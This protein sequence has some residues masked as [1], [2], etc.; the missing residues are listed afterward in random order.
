MNNEI[1]QNGSGPAFRPFEFIVAP[2]AALLGLKAIGARIRGVANSL[3]NPGF[4]AYKKT[5]LEKIRSTWAGKELLADP[6]LLG[7]RDLHIKVGKKNKDFRASPESLRR[8]FLERGRFAKINTLVDVYNLVS[9]KSGI[10]LGAHDIDRIVGDVTL[11]LTTGAET[12]VPLG[13]SAPEP[14]S[15]G[16]YAYVDDGN[17]VIC[18][19]EVIQ[20]EPTKTTERSRDIFL[21]IQGNAQ[22]PV[23]LLFAVSDELKTLITRFCGGDYELIA[24]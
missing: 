13:K 4:E 23:E 21:I 2:E 10:A 8:L 1:V 14:V 9:L 5:E 16:E 18:R 12:F 20:V 19:M 11:R 22:T 7:Y 15:A 24:R 3:E 6:I 17:N